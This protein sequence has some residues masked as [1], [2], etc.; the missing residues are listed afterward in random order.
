N[1]AAFSY[2]DGD[3]R[4]Q[5]EDVTFRCAGIRVCSD[6]YCI[7][8]SCVKQ[9]GGTGIGLWYDPIVYTEP[10]IKR[11]L[12][13]FVTL[14]ESAGRSPDLAIKNLKMISETERRQLVY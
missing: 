4:V 2:Y 13:Q 14:V 10:E 12:S 9:P 1:F 11:L 6:R 8:L 5:A 7:K 3:W